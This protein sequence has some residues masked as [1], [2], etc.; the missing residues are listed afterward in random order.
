MIY[1]KFEELKKS[2]QNVVLNSVH[3]Y[4]E[5]KGVAATKK[6]ILDEAKGALYSEHGQFLCYKHDAE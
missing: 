1:L 4:L 6:E 2:A 3:H 5:N